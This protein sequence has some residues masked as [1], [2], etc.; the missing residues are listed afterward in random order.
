MTTCL[1]I[2]LVISLVAA[3]LFWAAAVLGKRDDIEHGRDCE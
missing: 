1:T 3:L 2:Y